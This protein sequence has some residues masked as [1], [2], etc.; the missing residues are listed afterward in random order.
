MSPAI[1][2]LRSYLAKRWTLARLRTPANVRARQE[3]LLDRHP[4]RVA[5][6]IPFYRNYAGRPFAEWPVMDK[7]SALEHFSMLNAHSITAEQAWRIAEQGLAHANSSGRLGDLTVGTSSGTSGNRGLFLISDCERY[8]WLGSILARALPDFPFVRHRVAVILATGNTL[9]ETTRQTGRLAFAFFDL[10][11]GMAR[12]RAAMEAFAPDVLVASP[13]ALRLL[14][15]CNFNLRPRHIFAGG[16]VLDP[17]DAAPVTARYGVA[18]RSIYQAT[19]GFVA[20]ACRYGMIHLNE[21]DM[22]I[23]REAV[24]GHPDRFVPVITDLRL[25]AQAMIRYRLNDMLMPTTRRCACGSP[26]QAIER[27]EGRCDDIVELV[28]HGGGVVAVMPD[29]IRLAILDAE[30]RL[31]DFRCEQTGPRFLL[32]L[33]TDT[34]EGTEERLIAALRQLFDRHGATGDI[35]IDAIRGIDEPAVGKLRGIKRLK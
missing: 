23:E 14:V 30:R 20:I 19:E 1:A 18:P 8:R 10:R 9:Y 25:T 17:L 34:P 28:G 24:P 15:E 33:P 6:T 5:R 27:I 29:A 31:S 16:E 35:A 22:I 3:R 21:D 32:R 11:Q 4:G 26:F 13:K 7:V 2:I 12:H